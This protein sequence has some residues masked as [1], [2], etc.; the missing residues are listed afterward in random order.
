MLA[1]LLTGGV[2][3]PAEMGADVGMGPGGRGGLGRRCRPSRWAPAWL[4]WR[5]TRS[6]GLIGGRAQAGGGGPT[7][8]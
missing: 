7:G 1:G 6:V 2:E 8:G 3:E 5:R 4:G